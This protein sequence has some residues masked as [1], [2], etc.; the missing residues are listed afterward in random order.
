M[1]LAPGLW[2]LHTVSRMV[3]TRI[4]CWVAECQHWS[5]RHC[6]YHSS[7]SYLGEILE[8]PPHSVSGQIMKPWCGQSIR[9]LLKTHHYCMSFNAFSS[10]QLCLLYIKKVSIS[11]ENYMM[12]V[13]ALYR[14]RPH[15]FYLSPHRQT[16][17]QHL[18]QGP[19]TPCLSVRRGHGHPKPGDSASGIWSL[20]GSTRRS[21]DS[22]K[23]KYLTFCNMFTFEPMP[24]KEAIICFYVTWLA[25]Q[26]LKYSSHLRLLISN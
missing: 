18:F 9:T 2:C 20:S 23:R 19:S 5:Q 12:A 21:Y 3:S 1:L 6:T 11:L 8:R 14:N 13:Y 4:A 17:R 10:C 16:P 22:A 26:I 25:K 24:L 15:Q 7:S